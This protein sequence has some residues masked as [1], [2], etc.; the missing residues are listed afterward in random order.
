MLVKKF[1]K[2]KL[3]NLN[4]ATIEYT[5]AWTELG[6]VWDSDFIEKSIDYILD[7]KYQN[8]FDIGANTG[9]YSFFPIFDK[10]LKIW[11]FEPNKNVFDILAE[12]VIINNLEN[13]TNCFNIAFSNVN[14][15]KILNKPPTPRTSGLSTLGDRIIRFSSAAQEVVDC[16]TIDSFVNDC[17]IEKIDLIKIDTEGHEYFVL[18]GGINTIQN[19]KP[20]IIIEINDENLQQCDT[21]R[22]KLINFLENQLNYK[23]KEQIG[24]E[25]YLFVSK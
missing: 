16:R 18:D 7:K 23:L 14:E 9:L 13:N 8:I 12:N 21:S 24:S 22:N 10:N 19:M 1:I 2:E 6:T 5:G 17:G 11:S 3:V 20:D 25:D 15:R 4:E